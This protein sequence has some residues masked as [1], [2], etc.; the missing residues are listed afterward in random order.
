MYPL[1]WHH[2][3]LK[4]YAYLEHIF[5]ALKSMLHLFMSPSPITL[6]KHNL[7]YCLHNFIFQNVTYSESYSM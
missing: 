5:T 7:F 3:A 2:T 1:L 6:D 4:T